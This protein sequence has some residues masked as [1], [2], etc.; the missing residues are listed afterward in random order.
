V[1][2]PRGGLGQSS[3]STVWDAA[4]LPFPACRVPVQA[5]QI[6]P[7]GQMSEVICLQSTPGNKNRIILQTDRFPQ[8]AHPPATA[9]GWIQAAE[10]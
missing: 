9:R 8:P 2:M 6:L 7:I 10:G 1:V 3:S 4:F 5:V